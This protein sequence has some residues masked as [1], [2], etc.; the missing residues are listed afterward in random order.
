MARTRTTLYR[1]NGNREH[2]VYRLYDAE[3]TLLYVGMTFQQH[4]R[5]EEHRRKWWGEQIA[6]VEWESFPNRKT[7]RDAEGIA[8]NDENPVYNTRRRVPYSPERNRA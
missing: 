8:I 2:W 1:E 4:T 6:R 3:D 7:A 5:Y